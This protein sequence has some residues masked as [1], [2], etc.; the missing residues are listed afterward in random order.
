[1]KS[2]ASLLRFWNR[3]DRNLV[4]E[5]F[6]YHNFS[7]GQTILG[8]LKYVTSDTSTKTPEENQ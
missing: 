3:G 1:M 7:A 2:I 4:L 5:K 8:V 6:F